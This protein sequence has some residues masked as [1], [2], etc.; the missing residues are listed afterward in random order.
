MNNWGQFILCY[1][2]G[3]IIIIITIIIILK[4]LL[5]SIAWNDNSSRWVKIQRSFN[6]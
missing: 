6:P 3:R 2:N 4:E 5:R 1:R